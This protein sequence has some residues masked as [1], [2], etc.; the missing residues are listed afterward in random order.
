[1]V[2]QS[3][4]SFSALVSIGHQK[5]GAA[6]FERTGNESCHVI[7]RAGTRTT[8][9][10]HESEHIREA[11]LLLAARGLGGAAMVDCSHGNS[12]KNH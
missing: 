3:G 12:A 4:R 1:M 8:S 2:T 7:L 9:P 10:N 5:G 6:I 11:S